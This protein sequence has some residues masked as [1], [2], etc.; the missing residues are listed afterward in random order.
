M[1]ITPQSDLEAKPRK[2]KPFSVS[3]RLTARKAAEPRWVAA[4]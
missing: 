3:Q 4:S 2:E 1:V